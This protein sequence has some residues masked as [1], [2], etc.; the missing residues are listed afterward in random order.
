MAEQA[1]HRLVH[2]LAVEQ[3]VAEGWTRKCSALL[4]RWMAS[5]SL[6]IRVE[7]QAIFGIEDAIS[8]ELSARMKVSK[9]HVV[10]A[11]CHFAGLASGIDC[12][13]ASSAESGSAKRRVVERTC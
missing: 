11:R 12:T 3:N 4:T 1:M 2:V 5:E 7:E 6:V 8:R 9:N 13:M 10:C